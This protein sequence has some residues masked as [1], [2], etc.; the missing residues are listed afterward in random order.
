MSTSPQPV[1]STQSPV[2][3]VLTID[4]DTVQAAQ[5]ARALAREYRPQLLVDCGTLKCLR[6][7]GV[8]HVVSQLLVLH[9]S[10]ATIWLCNVDATLRTCL[11]LLRLDA[12]FHFA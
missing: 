9:Q 3:A 4:L 12:L 8:S 7:M 1:V 6:T 11:C 10:G 5:V 2:V